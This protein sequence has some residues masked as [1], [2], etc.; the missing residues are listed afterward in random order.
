M[1]DIFDLLKMDEKKKDFYNFVDNMHKK[2]EEMHKILDIKEKIKKEEHKKIE[3]SERLI[4]NNGIYIDT[5]DDVQKDKEFSYL[6]L[7]K[8]ISMQKRKLQ[9]VSTLLSDLPDSIQGKEQK[10]EEFK[11]KS[12]REINEIMESLES[13]VYAGSIY[14]MWDKIKVCQKSTDELNSAIKDTYSEL[15]SLNKEYNDCKDKFQNLLELEKNKN[16]KL[17]KISVTLQFIQNLKKGV[18]EKTNDGDLKKK[19]EEINDLYK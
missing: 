5:V 10:Y 17:K 7:K 1:I 3:E 14:E 9:N 16:K 13:S 4:K 2:N 11:K 12:R 18:N 8:E 19:L 15:S 6:N